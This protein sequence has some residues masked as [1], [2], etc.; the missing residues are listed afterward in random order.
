VPIQPSFNSL[1]RSQAGTHACH[2][3]RPVL[4]SREEWVDLAEILH[5]GRHAERLGKGPAGSSV[6]PPRTLRSLA[7]RAGR[8]SGGAVGDVFLRVPRPACGERAGVRGNANKPP[9]VAFPARAVHRYRL[10]TRGGGSF[11]D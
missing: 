11:R 8:G 6:P 2:R 9:P 5:E 7:P 4:V 1:T 3:Y 10:S